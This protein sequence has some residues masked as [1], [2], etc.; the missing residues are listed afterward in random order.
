M[1]GFSFNLGGGSIGSGAAGAVGHGCGGGCGAIVGIVLGLVMVPAGF[2]LT[3]YS[4]AK[5]VD[6]GRAFEA[7]PMIEPSEAADRDGQLVKI[8]GQ[9]EGEFLT[10]PEWDGEA[11][12]WRRTIEEYER[13]EDTD[14]EVSYDWNTESSDEDWAEF[15][16]GEVRVIPDGANPV[17]EKE[18][19]SAYKKQF[20]TDFHVGTS[21][22]DPEVGDRRKTV[23]VL[24]AADRVIVLGEMSGG[25]IRGGS[26]FVVSTLSETETASTLKSQYRVTYWLMKAGSV[27]LIFLGLTSIFIPLTTLFGYVPLIGEQLSCGFALL[28]LVFAL[29]SV[30]AVTFFVKAFWF[31]VIG[32]VLVIAFLIY[33]GATT[34]RQRG[35][36]ET[37]TAAVPPPGATVASAPRPEPWASDAAE[38]GA[39]A[40]VPRPVDSHLDRPEDVHG[41]PRPETPVERKATRARQCV[42]CGAVL[43]ADDRFCRQCGEPVSDD[44]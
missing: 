12:F 32:V 40:S 36:A 41:P 43:E 27:L 31:L 39:A 37:G 13:E 7:V 25:T 24:N 34:P 42:N 16:I 4:E 22:D 11:L 44:S 9:P 2:Y 15:S 10:I 28:A 1:A 35:G 20:E 30:A 23:E 26:S 6:H 21:R 14:G 38:P 5:L 17:G 8:S 19:Y 33:R 18:V 29:V 3:Y